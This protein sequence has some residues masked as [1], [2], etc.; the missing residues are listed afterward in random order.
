[1]FTIIVKNNPQKI[2]HSLPQLQL[3]AR[4][5]ISMP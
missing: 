5:Q 2:C 3:T 1:L 4:S